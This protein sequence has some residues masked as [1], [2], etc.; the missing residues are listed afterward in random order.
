MATK[1]QY[2]TSKNTPIWE[3]GNVCDPYD[4]WQELNDVECGSFQKQRIVTMTDTFA[5][6][7]S[8]PES[9]QG[10]PRVPERG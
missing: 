4:L 6:E 9:G 10:W 2:F 1:D 5:E 7:R 3:V 8:K